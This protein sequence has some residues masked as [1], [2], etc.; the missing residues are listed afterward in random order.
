MKISSNQDVCEE[1][2]RIIKENQENQRTLHPLTR[3]AV[4]MSL[5]RECLTLN[6]ADEIVP[7]I[8]TRTL[9]SNSTNDQYR[10]HHLV[11]HAIT[12][13]SSRCERVIPEKQTFFFFL[14]S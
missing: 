9:E 12:W 1:D 6:Q 3:Y 14:T 13:N 4:Q 8:W 10:F 11:Q 5:I 2:A 7:L